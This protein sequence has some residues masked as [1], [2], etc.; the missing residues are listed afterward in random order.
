[1]TPFSFPLSFHSLTKDA[2]EDKA[3]NAEPK[4]IRVPPDPPFCLN[5]S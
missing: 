1:M 4:T 3:N 2:T 5:N